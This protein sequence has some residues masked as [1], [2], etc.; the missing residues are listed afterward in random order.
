MLEATAL[1][2]IITGLCAGVASGVLGIGGAVLL[3]PALVFV[4][5][6]PQARAQGTSIG[7]LVP[8]IGIFAAMQYYRSGLLDVRAAALIACGFVFGALGGASVVP[9]IPQ[10]WLRRAFASVLVYVAAQMMF[11]DG[12]K[13]SA[14]VLPSAVAVAALWV[15]YGVGRVMGQRP[16]EPPVPPPA[17]SAVDSH[18]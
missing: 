16:P 4:F 12:T 9:F 15:I 7:A 6:F 5:G 11:S 14:A 13:R 10:T 17:S 2:L 3:V 1:A 8:P 18:E